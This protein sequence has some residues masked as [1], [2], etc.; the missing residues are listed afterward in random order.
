MAKLKNTIEEL[1]H[2][3]SFAGKVFRQLFIP[4]FDHNEL[5]KQSYYLGVKTLPLIIITSFILGLVLTLQSRPILVDFG[6]ENLLPGMVSVSI[7]R[8]IG[9]IITALICAGKMASGIGA[10]LGSMR[11][12]EQIDAMEVSGVKPIKYLVATRV[13]ATS[14]VV[15]LLVIFADT[16]AMAGSYLAIQL[17]GELSLTLF[18]HRAF[19]ALHFSD[20]YP[21]LI[22]TIF[23]GYFIGLIGS[24]KGYYSKKGTEAVGIAA[25]E[26]VVAASISIFIINL[27]SVQVTDYISNL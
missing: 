13:L 5:F 14:I 12:T 7:I 27:L 16:I 23:F 11:V 8:E 4:P 6:A 15:P 3:S 10:E 19:S 24:Y 9:P 17:H 21:S 1:G 22:K 18:I 20:I 25:N 2:I 26:A